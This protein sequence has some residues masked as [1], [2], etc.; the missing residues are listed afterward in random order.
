MAITKMM[1]MKASSKARIDIHLEHSINYILQPKKLG[2]ANLASGINCLP[3]MAY[4]QMKATKQM[5]GKT[6][7]RQ[8]YHFV[9]S[10]KPGEGTPEIMYDIA[11]QF[12][13]EAFAGEYEAVVAVHTDREHL[14]AHIVINSV[15]MVNGYKF[16]CRDGDWKYKFQPITNKLCEEYGLHITPAEYSKEP[17]NMARPQ[18]EREQ[19]FYEWIKQD[20]LFCAISAENMEHFIF[21]LEKLGFEVKQG[22]H[23]AVKVPGMKRFKRLDTISEDLS[24][25]RLEAMFRY[26][27]A[28]L[29]SPVNRTVSLLP[30]RKAVLTPYQRKCYARMY[31]L[32]LAEK[33]RFTYKSA[34]LYE[35]IRKMHELQEE[36]LVVVKYDVKSYGDLFRLK[37]RLQQVDE[38]LCKAQ[39][40]MYRD[41]ALQ[42]RSCKTAED[43]EFFEASE[44]DYRERLEEI[45]LQKK[46]NRKKLKAVER[47]LVRDGSLA[48]AEL[49]LRIPVDEME[50][51]ANVENDKV[52]ENPYRVQKVV[53]VENT[54]LDDVV[55]ADV[56]TEPE[57]EA[58]VDDEFEAEAEAFAEADVT[59]LET[60]GKT[61]VTNAESVVETDIDV[62]DESVESGL[63]ND[64]IREYGETVRLP[65]DKADY[66]RMSVAEKVRCYPFDDKGTDAAFEMV[67]TYFEKIGMDT[68]FDSVYEETKLL[69][70]YYEK[71]KAEEFIQK[72][73]EQIIEKMDMMGIDTEKFSEYPV[74]VL[75]KVFDFGDMEYFAGIKMFNQIR[76]KLGVNMAHQDRYELF[77]RIY[78]ERK[79]EK[80]RVNSRT[81]R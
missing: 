29:A 47:C 17:K 49:E 11:M 36:Y 32:R 3:E 23:I 35:Q 74:D 67:R 9:I 62:M 52:P 8:G 71:L 10:L 24:G 58:V 40:E 22:K 51:M 18:W 76:D 25:E 41:R 15:N 66:M 68:S 19:A 53:E 2:E 13:E 79:R 55:E 72:Q 44:G 56:V 14:H 39:K 45:K 43:L 37:Q 16:Q 31:R 46:D 80:K 65:S 26:G 20:A 70:D 69:T 6:G 5:F 7:G 81:L 42:K 28:S 54:A 64:D 75:S 30:V 50:D 34:Y 78:Q 27:D 77:D 59:G 4:Q 21:L 33:K 12:A 48:E 60:V 1:H 63:Q 61:A 38:E 57:F 73:T